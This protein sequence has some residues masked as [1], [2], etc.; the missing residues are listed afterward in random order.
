MSALG[1]AAPVNQPIDTTP[2]TLSNGD[3]ANALLYQ[4]PGRYSGRRIVVV[5]QDGRT[6]FDTGDRHDLGNAM[7]LYA[8]WFHKYGEPGNNGHAREELIPPGSD[9]F[10]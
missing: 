4:S 10:V 6:L 7:I 8:S 9:P 2:I 1:Y 3:A 5:A